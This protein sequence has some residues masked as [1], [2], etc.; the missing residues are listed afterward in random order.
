VKQYDIWKQV[1]G[2][3]AIVGGLLVVLFIYELLQENYAVTPTVPILAVIAF[4]AAAA[5][6]WWR[7]RTNQ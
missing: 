2:G 5:I 3:L 6:Y 4:G 1:A 7:Q